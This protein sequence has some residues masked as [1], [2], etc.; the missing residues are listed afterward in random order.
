MQE[1]LLFKWKYNIPIFKTMWLNQENAR[2]KKEDMKFRMCL[3]QFPFCSQV[4]Y[5]YENSMDFI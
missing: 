4:L 1:H 2:E 3:S 5:M